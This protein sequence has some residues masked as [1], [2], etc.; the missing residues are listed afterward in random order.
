MR[1]FVIFTPIV[2]LAQVLPISL[3][4]LGI[5]EGAFAVLFASVGV[6][7]P[8][9]VALS[10]LYQV[11]RVLTGLLGGMLYIVG[12]LRGEAAGRRAGTLDGEAAQ[13]PADSPTR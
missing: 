3:N 1:Y 13:Q 5:R 9:A 6:A 2:A 4:G 8:D 10:L 12:N 11:L 7:A